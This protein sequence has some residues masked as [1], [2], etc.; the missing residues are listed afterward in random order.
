MKLFLLPNNPEAL[1]EIILLF[2]IIHSIPGQ[3]ISA[4]HLQT[5]LY[6]DKYVKCS[7]DNYM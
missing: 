4:L 5:A 7:A 2:E 1:M 6:E 3:L